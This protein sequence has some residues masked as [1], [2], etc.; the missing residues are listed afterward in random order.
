LAAEID[1]VDFFDDIGLTFSFFI[2][3]NN[4]QDDDYSLFCWS[5][6]K[7]GNLSS[8]QLHLLQMRTI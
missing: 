7:F 5:N 4:Y 2:V 1:Y 8:G 6:E 3:M